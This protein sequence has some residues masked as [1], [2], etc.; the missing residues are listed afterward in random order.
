MSAEKFLVEAYTRRQVFIQ[1]FANGTWEELKPIFNNIAS[2]IQKRIKLSDNEV[3][4]K[5]LARLLQDVEAV[6]EEGKQEFDKELRQR[7]TEFVEE[8]IEFDN[9]TY[10]QVTTEP[11]SNPD[12]FN[13]SAIVAGAVAALTIG[14]ENEQRLTNEQMSDRLFSN[15]SKEVKGVI[16]TGVIAQ[17]NFTEL[18]KRV[19]QKVGTKLPN[20]ART[21]VATSTNSVGAAARGAFTTANGLIFGE[22]RYVAVLDARTTLT[23]AGLD[24]NIYAVNQGPKPPLHYNCRS[25]RV[26]IPRSRFIRPQASNLAVGRNQTF[27]Q[28]LRQ[29]PQ[30]FQD[31]FFGKFRNGAELQRLAQ[32]GG[33]NVNQLID[34]SGAQMTLQEIRNSYPVAWEQANL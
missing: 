17:T 15:T 28:F 3:R 9:Q 14:T 12:E 34:P 25:T 2:E 20:I 11:V 22:E 5:S 13:H 33:L 26:P 30:S 7:L 6:I 32:Q 10:S 31:E 19:R 1:R 23:C 8:E 18:L 27:A 24:G 4:Q 29:Q 16:S 21:V